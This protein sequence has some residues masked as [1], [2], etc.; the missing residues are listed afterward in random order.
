MKKR[1]IFSRI[2]ALVLS[3]VML[4]SLSAVSVFADGAAQKV[5]LA[6][7]NGL[8]LDGLQN[9]P[10]VYLSTIAYKEA[11]GSVMYPLGEKTS[12]YW[13]LSKSLDELSDGTLKVRFYSEDVGA[14]CALVFRNSADAKD[15]GWKR[16]TVNHSGWQEISISSS[17][18][19][20]KKAISGKADLIVF[21]GSGFGLGETYKGKAIYLDS[22]W[23]E[24]TGTEYAQQDISSENGDIEIAKT[25]SERSGNNI[26]KNQ[27]YTADYTYTTNTRDGG[28]NAFTML[29]IPDTKQY[30][31]NLAGGLNS[32]S[33]GSADTVVDSGYNWLNMWVWSP[34]PQSG[35]FG[36]IPI[37]DSNWNQSADRA[38]RTVD[39]SGWKLVSFDISGLT[40]IKSI[41]VNFNGFVGTKMNAGYTYSLNDGAVS[42]NTG[43]ENCLVGPWQRWTN[44]GYIGFENIWLSKEKPAAQEQTIP[45]STKVIEKLESDTVLVDADK[46]PVK[47]YTETAD[48]SR[49]YGKAYRSQDIKSTYINTSN[50]IIVNVTGGMYF[51]TTPTGYTKDNCAQTYTTG[52]KSNNY[53][54]FWMYLPSPQYDQFGNYSEY[55]LCVT[56][57]RSQDGANTK[58]FGIIANWSGWK[59]ISVK[60][61][62]GGV[63]ATDYLGDIYI[64]ANGYRKASWTNGAAVSD[65]TYSNYT[66]NLAAPDSADA[67]KIDL[68]ASVDYRGKD[69]NTFYDVADVGHFD[70]ERVWLSSEKPQ[71]SFAGSIALDE[72]QQTV[73]RDITAREV[74]FVSSDAEIAYVDDTPCNADLLAATVDSENKK[75]ISGSFG[76]DLELSGAYTV[77]LPTVTDSAGNKY[78]GRTVWQVNAQGLH[79]YIDGTENTIL[80]KV[81]EGVHKAHPNA[82]L[83]CAF[84]DEDG[85]TLENV[86]LKVYDEAVS[87][88]KINYGKYKNSKTAKYMMW[89][90]GMRPLIVS[91]S[92]Y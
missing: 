37:T 39:W 84:F 31:F 16:I 85:T 38:V 40:D 78:T 57:M 32:T 6:E 82:F 10:T 69:Y 68:E 2:T 28:D 73:N 44:G 25:P 18:D 17:D 1:K 86:E 50:K 91:N 63:N 24:P 35:G 11:K 47:G 8:S 65:I 43:T 90:D 20:F 12:L 52:I 67:A 62:S 49:I 51:A 58:A 71:T 36:I 53:L 30:N 27:S 7:M 64:S 45:S 54:N 22:V 9:N 92:L 4:L 88:Y 5:T 74:K 80:V 59:L 15:Y 34:A 21:N 26:N 60:L 72:N 87:G 55:N 79:A 70:I 13:T 81:S 76:K 77:A 83:I 89:T 3:A 33:C 29:Y 19:W 23:Y 56:R 41:N 48:N 46:A 61:A 75:I 42:A 14:Q 66:C